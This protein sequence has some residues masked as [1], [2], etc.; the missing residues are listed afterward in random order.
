[1]ICLAKSNLEL[2]MWRDAT[3]V[4]ATNSTPSPEPQ[5]EG[6]VQPAFTPVC[7]WRQHLD[8]PTRVH[9]LAGSG[10]IQGTILPLFEYARS[11]APKLH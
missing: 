4:G 1:M 9:E 3:D 10:D 7:S 6:V 11:V 5:I 8:L 2:G